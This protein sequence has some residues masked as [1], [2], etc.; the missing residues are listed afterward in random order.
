MAVVGLPPMGCLPIMITLNS[1]DAFVGRR[2]LDQFSAVAR[3]YNALLQSELAS[4]HGELAIRF[5]GT[6]LYYADIYE[7]L[8]G[9]IQGYQQY[10][11]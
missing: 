5:P 4:L 9:L 8:L 1:D 10:G 6:R 3:S 7:A 11:N 2:C